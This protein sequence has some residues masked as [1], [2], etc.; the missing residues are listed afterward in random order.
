M[1]SEKLQH[2]ENADRILREMIR[3]ENALLAFGED[4]TSYLYGE[5]K[6]HEEK[7][8]E[9]AA[10]SFAILTKRGYL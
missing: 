9:D 6:K 7:L 3:T 1:T 4:K 2:L 10:A 8:A 5:W